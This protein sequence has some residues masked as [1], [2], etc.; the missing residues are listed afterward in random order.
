M[1][2]IISHASITFHGE[3]RAFRGFLPTLSETADEVLE[4]Q[5]LNKLGE[6]LSLSA[7]TSKAT[8]NRRDGRNDAGPRERR[9]G[10]GAAPPSAHS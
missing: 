4:L 10:R 3:R 8:G 6:I 9:E 7:R 2:V 1:N 5:P